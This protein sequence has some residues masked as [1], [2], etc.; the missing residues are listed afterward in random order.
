MTQEQGDY[1]NDKVPEFSSSA[2]DIKNRQSSGD[3]E[4]QSYNEGANDKKGGQNESQLGGRNK[5]KNWNKTSVI[6]NGALTVVTT[7]I[8]VYYIVQFWEFKREF[9]ITHR[10]VLA[11]QAIHFENWGTVSNGHENVSVWWTV[12]PMGD[13]PLHI[14]SIRTKFFS[15]SSHI[16]DPIAKLEDESSKSSI[17]VYTDKGNPHKSF[18]WTFYKL[19]DLK[20]SARI[21][22][23]DNM[24][25][26]EFEY[27]NLVTNETFKFYTTVEID[28]RYPNWFSSIENN[29]IRTDDQGN[30]QTD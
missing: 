4:K 15:D 30:L 10:A 26:F 28:M 27:R 20:D 23:G 12:I 1:S 21:G 7:A 13:Q 3:G 6:I 11:L 2:S 17:S 24:A 8:F 5:H 22:S 25:F 14:T 19:K 18:F 16:H 9:R 29:N